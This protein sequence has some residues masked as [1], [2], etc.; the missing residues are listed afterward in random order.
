MVVEDVGVFE[1]CYHLNLY[2]A[3]HHMEPTLDI[4][5]SFDS[6]VYVHWDLCV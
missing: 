4:V 3:K 1:C 5:Y 2:S 6:Y